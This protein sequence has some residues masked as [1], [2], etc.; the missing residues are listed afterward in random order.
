M[1][2]LAPTRTG[3]DWWAGGGGCDRIQ[4]G[5]VRS[6]LGASRGFRT[7]E[8]LCGGDSPGSEVF[9]IFK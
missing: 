3:E 2:H 7:R 5:A 9:D 1:Y 4:E 6:G 8:V